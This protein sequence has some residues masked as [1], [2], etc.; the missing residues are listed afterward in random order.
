MNVEQIMTTD[1]RTCSLADALDRA[2]QIMWEKDCGVVPVVDSEQRV[3]GVITDRDICMAAYIQGKPLSAI[4]IA[5]IGAKSVV[6]VRPGDSAQDAEALMQK[7]QVRRVA[8]MDVDGRLVGMLSLN[9]LVR[10]ARQHPRDI[11]RD[12]ITKTL[13]AIGE[14]RVQ[15]N[16][17][18]V[19][20]SLS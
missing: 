1:L 4:S 7:H 10:C 17:A 15:P 20:G 14:P 5:S 6:A 8:V 16:P 18:Q 12:E 9:D 3:V 13:A 11:S 2:A 19:A